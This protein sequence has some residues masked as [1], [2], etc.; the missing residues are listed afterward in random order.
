MIMKKI[1]AQTR[2]RTQDG[3]DLAINKD[4]MPFLS[5]LGLSKQELLFGGLCFPCGSQL[6]TKII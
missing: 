6:Y 4:K 2:T 3:Q 5:S 1:T